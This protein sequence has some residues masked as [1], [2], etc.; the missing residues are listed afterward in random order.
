MWTSHA[1]DGYTSLTSHGISSEF[2]LYHRN[3]LTRHLPSIH[4]HCSISEALRSGTSEWGIKLEDVS[5]FTDNGSNIVKL[6]EEYLQKLRIPCAG[7]TLTLAVQAAL[8]VRRLSTV[9]ARCRKIVQHFNKSRVDKEDLAAKQILLQLPKHNLLQEVSTRWNS[10]HDM[11]IRLCEQQPAIAAVLHRKRDL[12]H[13]ECSPEEWRIL[14][15][16][17]EVLKQF[18]VATAYL[19]GEKYPTVSAV[20][21]LLAEIRNKIEFHED[22]SNTI[23]E[24]KRVLANDMDSRYQTNRSSMS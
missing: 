17:A 3:L 16:V 20:G 21:P 8:N 4:D 23:R 7:H 18:K 15:D 6:V 22:D 1:G 11:I 10:T 5:A 24:V 13:L 14:E 9:L 12:L 19:S 2:E